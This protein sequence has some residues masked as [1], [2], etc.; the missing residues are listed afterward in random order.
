MKGQAPRG[1]WLRSGATD[2]TVDVNFTSLMAAAKEAGATVE[3]HR[4]TISSPTWGY[5]RW[6]EIS[7][8]WNSSS[9]SVTTPWRG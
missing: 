1:D 3:L 9:L 2:V 7:A 6:C 4:Q 8:T 5:A